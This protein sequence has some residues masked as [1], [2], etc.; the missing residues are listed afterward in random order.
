[1]I[2]MKIA[3]WQRNATQDILDVLHRISTWANTGDE[4][5]LLLEVLCRVIRIEHDRRVEVCKEHDQQRGHDPVD[6]TLPR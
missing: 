6:W 3:P 4:S 2:A 5:A 1:M